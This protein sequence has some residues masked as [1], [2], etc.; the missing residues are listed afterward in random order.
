MDSNP[1]IF[2]YN[3]SIDAAPNISN[4]IKSRNVDK[5]DGSIP[6]AGKDMETSDCN[7][8]VNGISKI[9][10]KDTAHFHSVVKPMGKRILAKSVKVRMRLALVTG[11][12]F[13]PMN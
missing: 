11:S 10:S 2:S 12:T 13:E 3:S 9:S 7:N 1:G 4:G 8:D 6:N 5:C